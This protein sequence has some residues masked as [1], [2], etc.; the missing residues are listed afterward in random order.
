MD[1]IEEIE[2]RF[3]LITDILYELTEKVQSLQKEVKYIAE[4]GTP[5]SDGVERP[6]SEKQKKRCPKSGGSLHPYRF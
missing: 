1:K 5:E 6:V 2:N 3:E 4:R